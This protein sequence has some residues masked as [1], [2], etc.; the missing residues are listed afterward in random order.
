MKTQIKTL[1]V[2]SNGTALVHCPTGKRIRIES[3]YAQVHTSTPADEA[4]WE[5]HIGGLQGPLLA[6]PG[7]RNMTV[8]VETLTASRGLGPQPQ[9]I[10]NIDPV[11]GDITPGSMINE[12]MGLPDM[13]WDVNCFLTFQSDNTTLNSGVV[14]YEETDQT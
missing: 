9:S 1:N 8:D 4:H 5:M 10:L 13:W 6:R 12:T 7:S 11:T 3:I 2:A 14:T